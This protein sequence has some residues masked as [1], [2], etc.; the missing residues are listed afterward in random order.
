M[1]KSKILPYVPLMNSPV[2]PSNY[3]GQTEAA[4][5]EDDHSPASAAPT[6]PRPGP[7]RRGGGGLNK[8][9]LMGLTILGMMA[10][11]AMDGVDS[12]PTGPVGNHTDSLGHD[13]HS[14]SFLAQE[15]WGRAYECPYGGSPML[16]E[17]C[18]LAQRP[19]PCPSACAPARP[20]RPSGPTCPAPPVPL[21]DLP[22]TS[23]GPRR[24]VRHFWRSWSLGPA[25][26]ALWA[27][28]PGTPGTPSQPAGHSGHSW[29]TGPALR[30][31]LAGP[32]AT[33]GG[34]GQPARHFWHSEPP[35]L[36]VG[37]VPWPTDPALL[38]VLA[39][40]A[41]TSGVP[42]RPVR[43]FEHPKSTWMTGPA[44]RGSLAG[45]MDQQQ[46]GKQ[47]QEKHE[48]ELTV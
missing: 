24:P 17:K 19:F 7:R 30:E 47:N 2:L 23:G 16:E 1:K 8:P 42:R 46:D 18:Q 35:C 15:Q 33:S 38:A 9:F 27:N 29:T 28:L 45:M 22:G 5:V 26:L 40:L 4:A 20:Y 10:V 32:S 39:D 14:L 11:T 43:H 48:T 31:F 37:C 12:L 34:P 21:V 3:S 44:L 13:G 6:P 41:G 36:A 25:L